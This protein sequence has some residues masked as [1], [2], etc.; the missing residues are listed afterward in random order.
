M[1]VERAVTRWY[2]R[3]QEIE[4]E[5]ATLRAGLEQVQSEHRPAQERVEAEQRLAE[6]QARLLHL[7][8]CPKPMMG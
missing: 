5:I 8:P 6:A 1:G 2:A 3:R 4:R 7:G